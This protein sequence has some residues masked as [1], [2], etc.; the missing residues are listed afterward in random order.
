[1]ALG[2]LTPP[3]A[4]TASLPVPAPLPSSPP[5]PIPENPYRVYRWLLTPA[6]FVSVLLHG[7]LLFIPLPSEPEPQPV[8]ESE[9]IPLRSVISP[10]PEPPEPVTLP[11]EA[12]SPAPSPAA[13]NAPEPSLTPPP[14]EAIALTPR[15]TSEPTESPEPAEPS[16]AE[17]AAAPPSPI[18]PAPDPSPETPAGDLIPGFPHLANA[19]AGCF[20]RGDNCRRVRDTN[21]RTVRQALE[22]SLENCAP[23]ERQDL[24]GDAGSRVYE[25]TCPGQAR[26]PL[27]LSIF[28]EPWTPEGGDS[29]VYFI[30]E[31]PVQSLDN[32]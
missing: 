8:A 12:P 29:V 4:S 32:L 27:Y 18:P 2:L 19:Q 1:M 9:T 3:S 22:A 24:A 6:L 17:T 5:S 30:A 16:P 28:Q 11:P 15:T 31:E 10:P 20:N 13:P 23:R 26:A 25:L 21:S 14:P 7:A